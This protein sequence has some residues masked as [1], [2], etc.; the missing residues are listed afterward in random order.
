MQTTE[1]VNTKGIGLGLVISKKI[2][3]NFGG[4]I[5]FKSKWQKGSN[6]G[7]TMQL[8]QPLS[9]TT[10]VEQNEYL[11]EETD[12]ENQE[13]D[14]DMLIFGNPELPSQ[15]TQHLPNINKKANKGQ[16]D[17]IDIEEAFNNPTKDRCLIV[18]DEPFNIDS[19]KITLQCS[20]LDKPNFNFRNR[21]DSAFNGV[22]A[23]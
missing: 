15:V 23:V 10:K 13:A 12:N 22:D 5:G 11:F 6:F 3:E 14:L 17:D 20:T 4:M 19:L 8:E 2:V 16:F 21:V 9:K 18:D 7:F 1:S